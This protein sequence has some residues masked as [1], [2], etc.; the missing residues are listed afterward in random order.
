MGVGIGHVLQL[1]AVQ[2]QTKYEWQQALHLFNILQPCNLEADAMTYC[3]A[4]EILFMEDI[5]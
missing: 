2:S 5:S 1:A 3:D 4:V